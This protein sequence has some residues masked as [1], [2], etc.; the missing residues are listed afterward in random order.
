MAPQKLTKPAGA[1]KRGRPP[2][3]DKNFFV[4]PDNVRADNYGSQ[5]LLSI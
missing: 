2:A 4:D 3:A 5:L 1:V